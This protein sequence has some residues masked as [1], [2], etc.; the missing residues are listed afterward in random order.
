V[1]TV[2]ALSIAA[3]VLADA[4]AQAME[5]IAARAAAA[6]PVLSMM[7][8]PIGIALLGM[9][10]ICIGLAFRLSRPVAV[11]A[12]HP[13]PRPPRRGRNDS[14]FRRG[15][16]SDANPPAPAELP[17]S[18][19]A[20]RL[21]HAGTE[22]RLPNEAPPP[23]AASKERAMIVELRRH[24]ATRAVDAVTHLPATPIEI[25]PPTELAQYQRQLIE[26]AER[27]R[28]RRVA[29]RPL[30]PGQPLR[31]RSDRRWET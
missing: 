31:R 23:V 9:V 19:L 24:L 11:S 14:E 29:Q 13:Q 3:A 6:D 12:T 25:M 26:R 8:R 22:K 1:K 28:L 27:L 17:K 15:F 7:T 2:S 4:P 5:G 21:R 16:A 20:L 30:P 18:A 10:L